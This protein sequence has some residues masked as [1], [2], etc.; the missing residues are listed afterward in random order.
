[1]TFF[2]SHVCPEKD[3]PSCDLTENNVHDLFSGDIIEKSA[4]AG[5][6][7]LSSKVGGRPSASAATQTYHSKACLYA[8]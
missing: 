8:Q 5:G 2:L 6:K 3:V 4:N 1:M 7:A